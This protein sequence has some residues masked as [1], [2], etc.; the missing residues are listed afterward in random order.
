MEV[1]EFILIP[2]SIIVGLG[3]AEL[4]GGVVR[5]LRGELKVGLL[6]SIWVT[7]VFFFQVQW[8]WA[9]WE[10]LGRGAWLFPEF[11]V[12]IIGPIGLYMVAAML[13]PAGDQDES[14]DTHLLDQRRPFFL[15]MALTTA[16]Y[17]VS[18]WFVVIDSV[19]YQDLSRLVVIVLYGF[20]AITRNRRIHLISSLAIL[21]G[22]SWFTYFFTL[23]IG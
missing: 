3:I 10:M 7:L 20:L 9:S 23:Q 17:S 19:G 21:A 6:H 16:S 14:L 4:F 22:Q 12:F 8:L 11:I 13:F 15:L 18:G 2:S 5:A 1:Y